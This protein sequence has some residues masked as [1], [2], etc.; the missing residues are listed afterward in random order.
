MRFVRVR[1]AEGPR[2]GVL[3][4]DGTVAVAPGL[5]EL[6]PLFGDGGAELRAA[7]TRIAEDPAAVAPVSELELL[8]PVRPTAIRDFMAFEEHVAPYWRQN[9]L[10]RGPDVWYER[11]IGYQ[12][13]ASTV[14]GPA[15]P[16]RIPGGCAAFDFELE[17]GAVVDR[18]LQSA[19]PEEAAGAV[20]GYLVLCDWSARDL[21]AREMEAQL[22]PFKGKDSATSLGPVLATPDELAGRRAGKG[23]DLAMAA[24]VNGREYGKDNWSSAYWS[25]EELLSYASWNSR[26]E[27]GS[28]AGSGTCQ[29]G[30]IFELSLRHSPEEFPWLAEGDQVQLDVELLGSISARVEPPTVGP[31]PGL[32]TRKPG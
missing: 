3:G 22:G 32:R 6:E 21:Q 18:D 31:W 27:R 1:T 9:G 17:I 23:Y 11:P 19:S 15:E 10:S 26:V 7:G 4:D 12:S 28:I 5:S 8:A 29:G 14:L 13:T 25:F 30:C 16:V 24:T 20:A 2:I